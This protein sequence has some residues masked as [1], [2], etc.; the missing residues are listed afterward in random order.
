[1]DKINKKSK[2]PFVLAG[3][4]ALVL[5]AGF[6][7]YRIRAAG[8]EPREAP[9]Q[10]VRLGKSDITKNI[11]LSG[12]VK[13]AEVTNVYAAQSYPVK[14]IFVNV[15]DYVNEGDALAALDMSKLEND[16]AQAEV[17]K[18]GKDEEE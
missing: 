9:R 17:K 4:V 18:N 11:D 5:V 13:S 8:V 7:V 6:A 2:K 3:V 16:I 15:G 1:M 14:E 12:V 10:T